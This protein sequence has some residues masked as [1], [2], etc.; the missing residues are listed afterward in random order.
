LLTYSCFEH[1]NA[2]DWLV[3]E[4]LRVREMDIARPECKRQKRRR[5]AVL[6]VIVLVV[7][8]A[9]GARLRPAAPSVERGTVW[10]GTVKPG[11]WLRQVHGL[12]LLIPSQKSVRQIPAAIEA[13][14][15]RIRMLPGSQAKA[16]SIPLEMSQPQVDEGALDAQLQLKAAEAEYQRQRVKLE[17]DLMSQ[18]AGA[19]TVSANYGH[20]KRQA[21]TD[22]ALY[23]GGRGIGELDSSY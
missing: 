16:D 3:A 5:Q 13:T 7:V 10:T 23:Q 1:S 17:S 11:S 22:K 20:T 18:Q 2:V 4:L 21:D 9:V 12:G 19:P 8:V 14:L 15:V 6:I